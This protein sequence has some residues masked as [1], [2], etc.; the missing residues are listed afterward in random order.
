MIRQL[1]I[2]LTLLASLPLAA[3]IGTQT[4]DP[5]ATAARMAE[6]NLQLG[7]AYMQEGKYPFAVEKLRK[8]VKT[9]PNSVD[10]HLYLA[11]SYD[12]L[13]ENDAA[14]I[15]F[16]EALRVAPDH[17][18]THTNYGSFLCRLDRVPEAEQHFQQA[19]STRGYDTPEVAY[20]NAG[21]CMNRH[22]APDK[23]DQ[24]LR[25]AI[26]A[27]PEYPPALLTLAELSYVQGRYPEARTYLQ[28]FHD[29]APTSA[30]TLALAARIERQLGDRTAAAKYSQ[31]L[32]TRFPD[33]PEAR[34]TQDS[35]KR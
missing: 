17:A 35:P 4:Q 33:A 1:R 12:R 21:L 23:A 2:A 16:Q 13:G 14:E 28:R 22:G 10:A 24:Y 3:C 25:R 27:R 9:D 5:E 18:P 30:Q 32:K 20:T 19:A 11:V 8:A 31:I 29:V 34:E 15:H 6:I 26:E 7:V